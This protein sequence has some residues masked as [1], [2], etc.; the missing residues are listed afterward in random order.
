[1][2]LWQNLSLKNPGFGTIPLV[3]DGGFLLQ[4]WR[5]FTTLWCTKSVIV[6]NDSSQKAPQFLP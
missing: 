4:T 3:K 5:R 2:S 6:R 1:M